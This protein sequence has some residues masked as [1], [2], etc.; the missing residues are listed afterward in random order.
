[1]DSELKAIQDDLDSVLERLANYMGK[2]SQVSE[3]I[4][5]RTYSKQDAARAALSYLEVEGVTLET[6]L[7]VGRFREKRL[8][9]SHPEGTMLHQH[10]NSEGEVSSLIEALRAMEDWL[11]TAWPPESCHLEILARAVNEWSSK[12]GRFIGESMGL[13]ITSGRLDSNK[14]AK[15]MAVA[16]VF[17]LNKVN[18]KV[19]PIDVALFEFVGEQFGG[20]GE[21]TVSRAFYNEEG[22]VARE[23]YEE[24]LSDPNLREAL[25]P[26]ALEMFGEALDDSHGKITYWKMAMDPC[27]WRVFPD[28]PRLRLS[29]DEEELLFAPIDLSETD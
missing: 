4:D 7:R 1:M 23:V 16:C 3:G 12:R 15:Q 26:M 22:K 8:N 9:E 21:R 28:A 24:V 11:L 6:S 2:E 10:A 18:P 29:P 17:A 13:P 25:M 5:P 19:Y 27:S 20:M 14:D